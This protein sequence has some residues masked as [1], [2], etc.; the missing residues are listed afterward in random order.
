MS[1][2]V[3][4]ALAE[5]ALYPPVKSFLEAQGYEVKGEIRGCDVVARR[6]AEEPVIVE[7]KTRFGLPLLLQGV[8]RLSMTDAVYLAFPPNA[9]W[10]KHRRE[11]LKLCRRLGVGV[12]LVTPE[13]GENERRRPGCVE[14]ALDPTPYQP[15]KNARRIGMLL[16]EFERRKGDPTPG[17]QNKRPIITAYRQDALRIAKLLRAQETARP[18]DIKARLEIDKAAAI[19]QRDI[20][21]W[22]V[23]VER[24]V[25]SL[26]DGGRAA[27]QTY[28]A[29]V[30]KL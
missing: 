24:G 16:R 2:A 4:E 30:A 21:G 9:A 3:S 19:L 14:P 26:S 22:F 11:A 27:L 7:L 13:S 8:A 12:L 5:T 29:E 23:R 25:Y 6:G 18:A 20:Y 10:R 1:K 17:G 15:R 28:A